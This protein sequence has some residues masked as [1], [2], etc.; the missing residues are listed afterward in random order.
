MRLERDPDRPSGVTVL[1]NGVPS[2]YVD[3]EDPGLLTFEY[4]QQMAAVIAATGRGSEPLAVVH[5]GAA[6][7]T[8]ARWV[9]HTRPGSR[10]IGVDIDARLLELAREWFALPRSPRLRLRAADAREAVAG[11]RDASTD[12]LVRD[13]FAGDRTPEHVTTVEF[14]QDVLRVLRPGGVY[15]AN[16]AD[17]PPLARLRAELATA[18]EAVRGSVASAG[19]RPEPS[20][21]RV[22]SHVGVVAEPALLRSRRYGNFVLVVVAPGGDGL[23]LDSAPLQRALRTLPVPARIVLGADLTA[24]AASAA[25][26]RDPVI[27]P[28]GAPDAA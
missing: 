11:L 25:P 19:T 27:D 12:V 15:L 9:E 18:L 16:C 17:R 1:V 26:L 7:C 3:L 13:V 8:L 10:Q 5:L 22:R 21:R 4:M 14:V 24:L 20:D 6:G 23:D 28:D 2:S